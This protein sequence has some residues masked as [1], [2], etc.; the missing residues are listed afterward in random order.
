[1]AGRGPRP[2][3]LDRL[4]S[5]SRA[6][7]R[8][9]G[10]TTYVAERVAQPSLPVLYVAGKGGKKVRF[11]WPAATKRWWMNWG[12]EPAAE[13][14]RPTDWDFLLDTALIHARVWGDGEMNLLPELRLRV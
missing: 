1:M 10:T 5:S 8:A 9:A 14:F 7:L 4:A 11:V 13:R 6:R 12:A 2:K 3:D